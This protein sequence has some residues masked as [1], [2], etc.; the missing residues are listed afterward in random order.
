MLLLRHLLRVLEGGIK[1]QDRSSLLCRLLSPIGTSSQY[2]LVDYSGMRW[3]HRC[4]G[5]A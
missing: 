4:F 1:M 5:L 3:R 2:W